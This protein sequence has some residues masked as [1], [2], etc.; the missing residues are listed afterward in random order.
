MK[1]LP[2]VDMQVTRGRGDCGV[3]VLAM[4]LGREYNDVLVALVTKDHKRPHHDGL[5]TRQIITGAKKLGVALRLLRTWDMEE[6]IGLLTVEKLHKKPE[7]FAQ[8]LVLLKWGLIF[9]YDGQ[10]WEPET[11]FVQHDFKP[12][13]L[14]VAEDTE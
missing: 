11:Y 1:P 6:A 14:L 10:V 13:T 8:H 5:M 2:F 3:C 12:L 4:L 7:D 9:D